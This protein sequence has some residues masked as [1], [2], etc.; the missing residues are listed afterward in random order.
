M[1]TGLIEI[2]AG[3][4]NCVRN[5]GEVKSGDEVVIMTT[6]ET[7][8]VVSEAFAVACEEA[9]GKVTLITL[10]GQSA[11]DGTDATEF[12]P[13]QWWPQS[14]IRAMFGS[15]VTFNLTRW[16]DVHSFG[17]DNFENLL[18]EHKTRFVRVQI[19]TKE[20]LAS[21]WAT[22][23]HELDQLLGYKAHQQVKDGKRVRVTDPAGTD[24]SF[25]YT[26]LTSF[27]LKK[28]PSYRR[29]FGSRNVGLVPHEANGT[30]VSSSLHF[31]PMPTMKI[32][33]ENGRGTKIEGG[34]KAGALWSYIWERDKDAKPIYHPGPGV[35]WLE[36]CMFAIHPKARR[37]LGGY[38]GQNAAWAWEGGD[39]RAG[40]L[41]FG[42]GDGGIMTEEM[43]RLVHH[44]RDVVIHY[45][46]VTV[47]GK[48][49]IDNGH[50]LLL[51]D[52]EVREVAKK[53]GDPDEVLRVEWVPDSLIK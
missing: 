49:I 52:A 29:T 46:T 25:T 14:A 13:V 26:I 27:R 28:E 38:S 40:I 22:F 18:K 3:V 41:H 1:A 6:T 10:K 12:V 44:H 43:P 24:V 11:I 2:M 9:G 15:D 7:N 36:E 21:S 31:G 16:S 8:P 53:Y 37:V 45:P 42:F 19:N 5:W 35:N 47:D 32:T 34:G 4:R 33:V 39:R 23:P 17:Q 20:G 51:D 50:L 30:I 48:T